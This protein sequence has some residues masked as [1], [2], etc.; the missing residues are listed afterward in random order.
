MIR[1]QA[2]APAGARLRVLSVCRSL[3]TPDDP[4]S[5]VFVLNRLAAMRRYAEVEILQPVPHFPLVKPLPA[6]AHGTRQVRDTPVTAEPMFY[7][8]K[9][10]KTLDA[11]WLRRSIEAT[12]AAMHRRGGLD[13]IDAHFGYPDGAACVQVAARLGVPSFITVRGVE[14]EYLQQPG[15]GEQL[16]E[17]LRSATACICVSHSL[18]ELV[19]RHGVA[20]ERATVIHNAI[21]R[22]AFRPC[23]GAAARTALGVAG[24][25]PLI[26]SVGHLVVRKRHH[27]LIEAFARLRQRHPDAQLAIIGAVAFEPDYPERLRRLAGELRVAD[28]VQFVGNL[29][30][31]QVVQ[32]L[33]AADA[34]A[35]GTE[36]EGCCNAV[37][38]ALACGLPVVTTP[39]GDN[40]WF[41]RDGVNGFIVP[42]DD[43]GAMEAALART[44]ARGDWDRQRISRELAVGTWDGVGREVV[45]FFR[46]RSGL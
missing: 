39:A 37:L 42:V 36:R 4:S 11:M 21:D 31:P 9:F 6:W 26:V 38:E 1:S 25:V 2:G 7:V 30:Q 33:R 44:L 29:P 18:R 13:L 24:H 40:T 16:A 23:D 10:L 27:V 14:N 15:I 32:W 46:E 28:S 22:E 3:P 45:G 8:P 20:P 12:A 43:A 5:G 17:A 41:V 19:L 35:L 34:F